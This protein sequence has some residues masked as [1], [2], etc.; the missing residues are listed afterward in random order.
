[1]Q[2][3]K[4]RVLHDRNTISSEV[5]IHHSRELQNAKRLV[6]DDSIQWRN[7]MS[8]LFP[9]RAAVTWCFAKAILNP[10]WHDQYRAIDLR[11]GLDGCEAGFRDLNDS[12]L[13]SNHR[14][15]WTDTLR[16]FRLDLKRPGIFLGGTWTNDE[17]ETLSNFSDSKDWIYI[18]VLTKE[19]RW[20]HV[21]ATKTN[22][23]IIT[24]KDWGRQAG[25]KAVFSQPGIKSQLMSLCFA[26]QW[27]MSE[28]W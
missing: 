19:K 2:P 20:G 17:H 15:T 1:M 23:V 25:R 7:K 22:V 24:S 10:L 18:R 6:A 11:L 3:V 12:W 13:T 27:A 16:S 26:A 5:T 8:K 14:V 4:R 21:M 9:S 28:R